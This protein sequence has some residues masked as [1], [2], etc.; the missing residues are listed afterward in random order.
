MVMVGVNALQPTVETTTHCIFSNDDL[1]VPQSTPIWQS[2]VLWASIWRKLGTCRTG[3]TTESIWVAIVTLTAAAVLSIK[4][5]L[6]MWDLE[7]VFFP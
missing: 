7:K 5:R 2:T 4:E 1:S 3:I 6:S